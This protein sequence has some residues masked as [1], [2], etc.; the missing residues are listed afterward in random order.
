MLSSTFE[1]VKMASCL[2][3]AGRCTAALLFV[4]LLS[5]PG[6]SASE[7]NNDLEGFDEEPIVL[8][9]AIKT[10]AKAAAD[11]AAAAAAESAEPKPAAMDVEDLGAAAPVSSNQQHQQSVFQAQERY[12][13]E[14]VALAVLIAYLFNILSGRRANQR[15]AEAW[16]AD[17]AS[18][19]GVFDRN[20]SYTG[21][22][23]NG[24]QLIK[25]S[26]NIFK[27]YASG[28]RD[29][30]HAPAVPSWD[31]SCVF[32]CSRLLHGKARVCVFLT[33]H[34]FSDQGVGRVVGYCHVY[35]CSVL[36][37]LPIML[38]VAYVAL[39]S[40]L[41]TCKMYAREKCVS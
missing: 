35:L 23:N 29:D 30:K 22:S 26:G 31:F 24:I 7:K 9:Q 13:V 8:Q 41:S 1:A 17:F 34:A 36:I 39:L 14:A 37:L 20:F 10:K 40:V 2:L 15:I 27:F 4:L 25:E 3:T 28:E 18:P 11:A 5:Y 33:C 12:V 38:L 21:P 32:L 6:P 16:A 19:G